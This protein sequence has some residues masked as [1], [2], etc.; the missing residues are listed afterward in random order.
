MRRQIRI[1]TIL[2]LILLLAGVFLGG[3][4]TGQQISW[5]SRA[6]SEC[7]PINLQITNITP[8]SFD[9]SFSTDKVCSSA[10]KVEGQTLVNPKG[11]S[12]VHY[13]SVINLQPQTTYSFAL[14]L[15]G[16]Q[17]ISSAYQTRTATTPAGAL[18][19]SNLAWGRVLNSDLSPASEAIVYLNIPGAAP[20]SAV[21]T[22]DGHWHISLAISL[23]ATKTSWFTPPPDTVEDIVVISSDGQTTQIA[24]NTSQNNP[25]AD[26]IVGQDRLEVVA[27]PSTPPGSL[28]DVATSP[29]SKSFTLLNPQPDE[30]IATDRPQFFGTAPINSKIIIKV[31]SPKTI[32]DETSPDST[33]NWSW[34]PPQ[35]LSPGPHTVTVSIQDPDT[36]NWST[37][38]RNFVV[39]AADTDSGLAY[40]ASPSATIAITPTAIPTTRPSTTSIPTSIP[41]S[42]IAPTP[43]VIPTI[44]RTS[45]PSTEAGTL[46]PGFTL[47]TF[48]LA[49]LAILLF[50]GAFSLLRI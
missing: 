15:D 49:A 25:V 47:P 16:R 33:G 50:L 21:T 18:P 14:I 43:T 27:S 39:L 10:L 1:P 11:N 48:G 17:I 29:A 40:T 32:D 45:H 36:L 19:S 34:V 42:T 23:D 35:G 41:T 30:T 22:S 2:G 5:F 24:G 3:K 46:H 28:G 44:I 38:T 7:Q 26:I 37:I 9:V 4:L 8:N 13:F 20:L 6:D 31:E 12:R